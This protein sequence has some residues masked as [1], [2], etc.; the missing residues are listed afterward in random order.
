MAALRLTFS[1]FCFA[2]LLSLTFHIPLN[3]LAD[4]VHLPPQLEQRQRRV[5]Q[6][7]S[8]SGNDAL[9]LPSPCHVPPPAPLLPIPNARQL[10]WQRREMA[11]FMHFGVNTFTNQ[12]WGTGHEDP[13]VFAPP[14]IFA[15]QWISAAKAG[16]FPVRPREGPRSQEQSP[17]GCSL[18]GAGLWFSQWFSG[19]MLEWAFPGCGQHKLV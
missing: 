18:G 19:L 15:D 2:L 13:S 6:P 11:M 10:E 7:G 8:V 4:R 3:A 1:P 14:A 5:Q 9:R 12:E 17:R 16:G